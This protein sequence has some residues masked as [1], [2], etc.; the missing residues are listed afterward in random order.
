MRITCLRLLRAA[1]DRA[2]RPA[3]LALVMLAAGAVPALAVSTR[4]LVAL[5]AGR[6]E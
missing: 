6:V 1:A 4:D 3:V 5:D 2:L